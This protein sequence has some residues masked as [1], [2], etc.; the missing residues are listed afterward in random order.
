LQEALEIAYNDD[1]DTEQIFIEPPDS[2]ILTD[3][4]SA[5]EDGPGLLDNLSGPQ[6]RAGAEIRTANMHHRDDNSE[7]DSNENGAATIQNFDFS[8]PGIDGTTWMKGD[9]IPSS[10]NFPN[11][12]YSKYENL[13]N[14]ETFEKFRDDNIILFLV[15]ESTKYA[16]FL[17]ELNPKIS[18]DEMRC[19]IAILSGYNE[20]PGQDFYW[21]SGADM[22]NTMVSGGQN[23]PF[24]TIFKNGDLS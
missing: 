7:Q 6:L 23:R 2:N 8:R 14:V 19:A 16:L 18:V 10:R 5:A 13:T 12:Y 22:K 21:D 15:E 20:L 1:I 17:N 24:V 9:L 11:F 3:E 4:D